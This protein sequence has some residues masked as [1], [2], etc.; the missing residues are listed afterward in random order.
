MKKA[1][2]QLV[3]L[4]GI[5]LLTGLSVESNAQSNNALAFDGVDDYVTLG[6]NKLNALRNF[7]VSAWVYRTGN[8]GQGQ[9]YILAKDRVVAFSIN[10]SDN[11]LQ[12]NFGNGSTWGTA[13]V[14]SQAIPLNQWVHVA[15]TRNIQTGAVKLFVNGTLDGN[16]VNTLT[17]SAVA[18]VRI[19][20]NAALA[21]AEAQFDG[22]IDELRIWSK[23]LCLPEINGY[24]NCSLNNSF[25]QL[26][27]SFNFNAGLPLG[28]NT[29][30]LTLSDIM[31]TNNGT[32]VN[33]GL[34]GLVSNWV[35]G[36]P[37]VAGTCSQVSLPSTTITTGG[38]T[39]V[40][41]GSTLALSAPAAAGYQWST[42]ATSQTINITSQGSYNVI[43][44]DQAGC[45]ATSSSLTITQQANSTVTSMSYVTGLV[46]SFCKGLSQNIGVRVTYTPS[47]TKGF[48]LQA[49][50]D[51]TFTTI[52]YNVTANLLSGSGTLTFANSSVRNWPAGKYFIRVTGTCVTNNMPALAPINVWEPLNMT[53]SNNGPVCKG[54]PISMNAGDG[55]SSYTWYGPNGFSANIKSAVINSEILETGE[56]TV[57]ATNACGSY[58]ANTNVVVNEL[59]SIETNITDA[60]CPGAANGMIDITETDL[61]G[62]ISYRIND[63]PWQSDASFYGLGAGTYQVAAINQKGCSQST[64]VTLSDEDRELPVLSLNDVSIYLDETGNA[65]LTTSMIDNGSFDG[66]GPVQLSLSNTQYTV[67]D[68]GGNLVVVTATDASG[69][70]NQGIII[71][72]VIDNVSPTVKLYENIELYLDENGTANIYPSALVEEASDASGISSVLLSETLFDCSR[73][74]LNEVEVTVT[75]NNGNSISSTTTI[76]LI[77]T[78]GPS[79]QSQPVTIQLGADGT[80]QVSAEAINNGSTDACGIAE[81]NLSKTAFTRND[82]GE[83]TIFLTATDVHGNASIKEVTV[84]VLDMPHPVAT[85]KPAVIYLN[86]NG[87]ATL[88]A[89]QVDNGS[90]DFYGTP[91]L[92]LSNTNFT[93]AQLGTN[94]VTLTVTSVSGLTSSAEATVTVLDDIAPVINAN[95]VTLYLNANGTAELTKSA[96]AGDASD[97]CGTPFITISRTQFN[98][99]DLGVQTVVVMAADP[100][101]NTSSETVQVT[102]ADSTRPELSAISSHLREVSLS[103]CTYTV[104]GTELDPTVTDN[105]GSPVS[106]AYQLSGATSGSG[107][108]SLN[109]IALNK[110]ITYITWTAKDQSGNETGLDMQVDVQDLIAPVAFAKDI[111]FNVPAGATI[112][113][114]AADINNGSYDNCGGITLSVSPASI[115][116][117]ASSQLWAILTITDASGNTS[118]DSAL[119]DVMVPAPTNQTASITFNANNTISWNQVPGVGNGSSGAISPTN[120]FSAGPVSISSRGGN[121]TANG[122]KGIGVKG[123]SGC[124]TSANL[125]NE[126]VNKGQIVRVSLTQS[127]IGL[128]AISFSTP[129]SAKV[130]IVGRRGGKTVISF[131]KRMTA[132]VVDTFD[133]TTTCAMRTLCSIDEVEFSLSEQN[134]KCKRKWDQY[135]N[136]DNNDFEDGN[137]MPENCGF[138]L[139]NLRLVVRG[140]EAC[141]LGSLPY[142]SSEGILASRVVAVS[143]QLSAMPS[144][145]HQLGVNSDGLFNTGNPLSSNP[146]QRLI[147]GYNWLGL[148][149]AWE[150]TAQCRIRSIRQ[151]MLSNSEILPV[152]N[153][154]NLLAFEFRITGI[155]TTGDFIYGTRR[156]YRT[157]QSVSIRWKVNEFY[158]RVWISDPTLVQFSKQGEVEI[159]ETDPEFLPVEQASTPQ[160]LAAGTLDVTAYPNPSQGAYHFR[161]E[162]SLLSNEA[163]VE[164]YDLTGHLISS[165]QYTITDN[166]ITMENNL[167]AGVYFVKVKNGTEMRLMKLTRLN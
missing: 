53:A 151:G 130:K 138:A 107:L 73:V 150:V 105:S 79:V 102:I 20:D 30:V 144:A 97:N 47:G 163:S 82:V 87:T 116:A 139:Q 156:N 56:Y 118:S 50:R 78:T 125:L 153:F 114:N 27:S 165:E 54:Q 127:S 109:G 55:A 62:N 7:S 126:T 164:V 16:A 94:T 113:L 157:N 24:R 111:T 63:L 108:S 22:A 38:G 48:Q 122:S 9:D 49:S 5:S 112:Q 86:S 83:N 44:Y 158:Q 140:R 10:N 11:K 72:D 167:A 52:D 115:T 89:N 145:I 39:V 8:N 13:A 67:N 69:N 3:L 19:G 146:A 25:T 2:L 26:T 147:V 131:S 1:L 136:P 155:S 4:T 41:T 33:F 76:N 137:D 148:P 40:C 149:S 81:L 135:E 66:C 64:E 18:D 134:T 77:D 84:T 60:T 143:S 17:G 14:S 85:T 121:L 154:L 90:S 46:S 32:L 132:N 106:I 74:G 92:S 96:V 123:G 45:N 159:P 28:S 57:I 31:N 104:S 61:R 160:S 162:G 37:A 141:D 101:G 23:E 119:V 65:T 100:Q 91:T 117:N 35:P 36:A 95:P 70:T 152:G 75:D 128:T 21:D 68:V 59:P 88:S 15:G 42:G 34:T 133:F 99:T 29:S 51:S 103:G 43:V 6:T 166:E 80:A 161:F 129:Y 93:C 120:F 142:S 110:G 98:T 58:S 124:S 71:V 12:L